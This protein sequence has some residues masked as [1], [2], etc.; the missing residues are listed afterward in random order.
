MSPYR[1]NC[2]INSNSKCQDFLVFFFFW[3]ANYWPRV[4]SFDGTI[5]LFYYTDSAARYNGDRR[6][7]NID[8]GDPLAQRFSQ[9]ATRSGSDSNLSTSNSGVERRKTSYAG[10]VPHSFM[11]ESCDNISEL[12]TPSP[13]VGK[14]FDGL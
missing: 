1:N 13:K 6:G 4:C 14:V 10:F 9:L 11:S 12:G 2:I 5:I 7:S 3:R 8:V